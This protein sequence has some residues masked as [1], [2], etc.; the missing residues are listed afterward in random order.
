MS[1]LPFSNR[2]TAR[3]SGV[4]VC[5]SVWWFPNNTTERG[6]KEWME[7]PVRQDDPARASKHTYSPEKHSITHDTCGSRANSIKLLK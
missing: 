3:P 1:C 7:T 2:E 4:C 5:V 6:M